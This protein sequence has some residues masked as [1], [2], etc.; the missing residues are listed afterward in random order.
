MNQNQNH[1]IANNPKEPDTP[2]TPTQP[3]KS[4]ITPLHEKK[5]VG[6]VIPTCPVCGGN[7]I[8]IRA[9]LQCE[10]CHRICETCCEGGRG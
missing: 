10:Q 2:P 4:C 1:Q 5:G 9:K 8:D 6:G 3:L 7:L